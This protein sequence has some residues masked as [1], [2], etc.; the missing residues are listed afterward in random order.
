MRGEAQTAISRRQSAFLRFAFVAR[1]FRVCKV[2]AL[3][4]CLKHHSLAVCEARF[5]LGS[6]AN[7]CALFYRFPA[8]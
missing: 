7:R 4:C 5:G 6:S 3:A 1:Y 2:A 8:H